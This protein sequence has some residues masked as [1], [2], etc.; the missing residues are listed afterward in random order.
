LAI[1]NSRNFLGR[2]FR[3][4]TSAQPEAAPPPPVDERTQYLTKA[5][6]LGDALKVHIIDMNAGWTRIIDMNSPTPIEMTARHFYFI[7]NADGRYTPTDDQQHD[8]LRL[9]TTVTIFLKVLLPIIL[10]LQLAGRIRF[11]KKIHCS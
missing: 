9:T 10:Y 1:E 11:A 5:R 8:Q 7:Q 2:L 3:N 6:A 4:R